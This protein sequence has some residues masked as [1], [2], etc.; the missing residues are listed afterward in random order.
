ME[1]TTF[2]DPYP[3]D[4]SDEE[5]SFVAPYLTLMTHD[6]PQRDH[7]LREV[8]NA[9]RWVVR[10]GSPWRYIPH[11]LP[12]W[13][14]VYQQSQ[15]WIR[16]GVFEAIVADL[17]VLIRL[18]E[19]KSE[20][21]T[22]AIFDIAQRAPDAARLDREWRTWWLRWPQKT[23]GLETASGGRYAG[24]VPDPGGDARE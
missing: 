19:G 10:T 18:G 6:A 24:R 7:N 16:A 21:P 23:Q 9:L 13:H 1:A 14:T 4:V 2:R 5:W 11:D 12:P 17:R 22:A 3:S 15:R 20:Q 8:F